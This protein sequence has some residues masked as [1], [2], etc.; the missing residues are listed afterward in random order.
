MRQI[1]APA[2]L[3]QILDE[4]APHADPYRLRAALITRL[5]ITAGTFARP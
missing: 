3:R 1:V 5:Q 4:E 2:R